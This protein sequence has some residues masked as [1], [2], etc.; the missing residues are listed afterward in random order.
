MTRIATIEQAL[1]SGEKTGFLVVVEFHS[2][3]EMLDFC[4]KIWTEISSSAKISVV[5]YTTKQRQWAGCIGVNPISP[6][7]QHSLLQTGP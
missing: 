4:Q 2:L 1:A 3:G 6:S 5:C 7:A